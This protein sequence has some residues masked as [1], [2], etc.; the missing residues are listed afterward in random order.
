MILNPSFYDPAADGQPYDRTLLGLDPALPTALMMFGGE[1]SSEMLAIARGLDAS[2]LGVQLI[3]VCGRNAKLEA[4]LR[5]EKL[6]IPMHVVGFTTEVARLMRLSDFFIGKPGPASISEALE[7]GLP[8]IIE[9]NSRT[10]PQERYNAEWVAEGGYGIAVR[11]LQREI[12]TAAAEMIDPERRRGFR[13]RVA[14]HR[15]R[16]VFE[17]TCI[18][19]R[20]LSG[21]PGLLS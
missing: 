5:A 15:N 3:A 19:E 20:I 6:R 1:G 11:S 4:R 9:C 12:A 21:G 8:V 16:A 2:G 14:A 7:M 10:M 18:L 17:I 13:E